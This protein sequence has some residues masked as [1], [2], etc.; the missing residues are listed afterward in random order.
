MTLTS[1][2]DSG[3]QN[4]ELQIF[5]RFLTTVVLNGAWFLHIEKIKQNILGVTG[6]YLRDVTNSFAP[7][8]HLNASHLNICS[9]S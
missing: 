5:F 8:L 6:V 1:F 2:Q 7:V 4:H 9:S 3:I